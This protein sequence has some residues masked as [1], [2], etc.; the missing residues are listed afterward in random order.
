MSAIKFGP[1]QVVHRNPFMEIEHTEA[2]FGAFKK[3]YFVVNF[4]PRAGIVAVRDRNVLL[5]RQYRFLI[6]TLSWELPGGTIEQGE[7]PVAGA[8]RECLEETGV[9][10]RDLKPLLAYYPG[11]D[12]VDNRTT[13]WYSEAVEAASPFIANDAEV[14]EVSW[15]PLQRCLDMIFS[16]EILDVMSV[17][18]LLAYDHMQRGRSGR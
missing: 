7:D 15:I 5:T 12:N 3:N 14:V 6:D 1:K 10:C 18:G 9:R 11:L 16:Q 17:A 13:I 8:V 4:G 2:D